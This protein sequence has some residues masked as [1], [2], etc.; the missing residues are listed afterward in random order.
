MS[1]V[2]SFTSARLYCGLNVINIGFFKVQVEQTNL[3]MRATGESF[4]VCVFS[5]R[6][7]SSIVVIF[8]ICP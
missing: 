7:F 5:V 4:V 1:K 6:I 2:T 8:K 3:V